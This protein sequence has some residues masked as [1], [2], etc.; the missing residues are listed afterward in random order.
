MAHALSIQVIA[1]DISS[2][3]QLQHLKKFNADYGQGYAISTPISALAL[4]KL[5]NNQKK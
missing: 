5:L 1:E 4:E 3:E 2:I